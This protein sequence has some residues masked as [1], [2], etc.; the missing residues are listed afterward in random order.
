VT[1][2]YHGDSARLD[3]VFIGGCQDN[4]SNRVQAVDTPNDWDLIFGGDGG[5]TAIDPTAGNVMY[6]EYQGFPTIYKSVNGGESFFNASATITD[7]DGLFITPSPW[8]RRTLTS[9]GP[10]AAGPGARPTPPSSG[11]RWARTSPALT[12]SRPSASRRR[13]ATWSISASTTATS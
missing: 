8:T 6:V 5:Y 12:E 1:Q 9:S 7:T 3:D 11:S 10:E 13:T 4:G 2:F